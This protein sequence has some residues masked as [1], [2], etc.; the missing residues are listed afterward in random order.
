MVFVF[1]ALHVVDFILM[2]IMN[3]SFL[4][5]LD[6]MLGETWEN[7]IEMLKLTGIPL[8]VWLIL[9]PLALTLPAIGIYLYHLG[10]L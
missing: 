2:R 10:N 7:F 1:F 8:G 9:A 4:A 6:M 3:L 5:A